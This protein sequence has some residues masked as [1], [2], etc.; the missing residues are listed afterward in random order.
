MYVTLFDTFINFSQWKNLSIHARALIVG[1]SII[2]ITIV[3]GAAAILTLHP[4]VPLILL[5]VFYGIII[6]KI[7]SQFLAPKIQSLVTGFLGGI[8]AGNIGVQQA[9]LSA[10]IHNVANG[11]QST[12]KSIAAGTFHA[13][14]DFTTAVVWAIWITLLTAIVILAANAYYAN[15]DSSP[16]G[17]TTPEMPH[18]APV[19]PVPGI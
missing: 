1:V 5:G 3:L 15:L 8:T 17:S 7:L 13:D 9:R 16:V 12:A 19:V 4:Y 6:S 11:I 18:P 14:A 2:A 10:A